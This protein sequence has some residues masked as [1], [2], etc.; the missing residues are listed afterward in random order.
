MTD[1]NV[2]LVGVNYDKK[3]KQHE[4][5]IEHVDISK[6]NTNE[7]KSNTNKDKS[8]TNKD[9]SNTNDVVSDTKRQRNQQSVLAYCREAEHTADEI[10]AHLGISRQAKHYDTYIQQLISEGRLLDITPERKRDKKYRT[11]YA[12]E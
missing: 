2:V 7:D 9:K 6:S 5:R 11:N 4:C 1:G 10:F 3:I 8:N 12:N